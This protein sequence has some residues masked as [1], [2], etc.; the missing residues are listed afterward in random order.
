MKK[1]YI[2]WE[3]LNG[4][5][6]KIVSQ[7]QMGGYKPDHV[8]G[9]ANGGIPGARCISDIIKCPMSDIHWS[10]IDADVQD[11]DKLDKYIFMIAEGKKL[12]FVDDIVDSGKTLKS[13]KEALG[14][15][16]FTP[17]TTKPHPLVHF[18]ALYYNYAQQDASVD[19]I[20]NLINR[21]TY[22]DWLVFPWEDDYIEP[23]EVELE[24]DVTVIYNKKSS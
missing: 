22:H 24:Q 19:Y 12:L 1:T 16:G 7:M 15:P 3:L 8:V 23:K 4:A 21:D 5:I 6:F 11:L 9:V 18:A 14:I 2:S 17:M 20:G 10:F 13:L